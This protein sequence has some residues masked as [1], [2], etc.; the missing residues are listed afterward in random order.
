M[1]I[2]NVGYHSYEESEY[3]QLC[4]TKKFNKK[5]F[6]KIVTKATVN[7]LKEYKIKKGEK[8]S[9]Q[10]ILHEVVRE[11]IKNFGFEEIKFTSEFN[12]F[13]WANILDEKDWKHDRDEQL[14]LLTK[15]LKKEL[16]KSQ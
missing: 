1:Y 7:I 12:V 9:F 6:E 13:G 14:K 15:L 8:L 2:Y 10:D 16:S 3:V 5:E 4:H 11:L